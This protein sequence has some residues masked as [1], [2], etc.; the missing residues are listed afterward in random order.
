MKRKMKLFFLLSLSSAWAVY[1][2]GT[3]G[4]TWTTEEITIMRSRILELIEPWPD[5]M[6]IMF[7]E[8]ERKDSTLGP[9]SDNTLIIRLGFHDCL[10][11]MDGTGGYDAYLNWRGMGFRYK[12][13]TANKF[14]KADRTP[15]Y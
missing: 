9:V 12:N 2:P 1:T 5:S 10:K 7:G 4:G 3:P 8:D 14:D 11:Y 13:F 6:D 15:L